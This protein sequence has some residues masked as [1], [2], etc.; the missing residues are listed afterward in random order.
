MAA[1]PYVT[2]YDPKKVIVTFGGV[3]INGFASGTFISVAASAERYQRVTG[4][5]GEV[6]RAKSADN[7]HEVTITL[8]QASGSN[9]H[10]HDVEA[11]DRLA[12]TGI[13]ELS[14]TD[15]NGETVMF[16]PEAWITG[17]PDLGFAAEQTD[18]EWTLNTG[19]IAELNVGGNR[20]YRLG[21]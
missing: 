10:L 12:D 8:L 9:Q 1:N 15:L 20:R 4:A 7:T 5:D 19:Q 17:T 21:G 3:P 11:M 18:R 16:W 13:R 14:I 6:S 2:T